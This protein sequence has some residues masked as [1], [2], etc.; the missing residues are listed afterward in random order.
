MGSSSIRRSIALRIS[1]YALT[2]V[3]AF[4]MFLAW[5]TIA[6]LS[7]IP[8]AL[9]SEE[10][11]AM[12]ATVVA[13]TG[14]PLSVTYENRWNFNDYIPLHAI[15]G[16]LRDAFIESEDRRFFRHFGVDVP[17]RLQAIIQNLRALRA[18]RGASTITEQVVRMLHPRPRT[19]W[20]RWLEGFEAVRLERRFSKHEI[21]EFYL[22]QV[23]YAHQRRGV[24]QASRYYFGRDTGE[25]NVREM[26]TL[27]VLV[28]AP[29]H[30]DLRKR[31]RRLN[32]GV[33][34]LARRMAER[35]LIPE[36]EAQA[37]SEPA[38]GWSPAEPSLPVEAGHFVR[39]LRR[40][41]TIANDSPGAKI[42][43]TLDASLQDRVE[44]LLNSR[45]RDLQS[46]G[47]SDGAA[48]VVD[49]RT[50][51]ILAWV[52]GR[53]QGTESPRAMI[54]AVLVPR[55]P[56]ST[57]KP[58]LYALALES[59]WTP[60]TL[61]EDSPLNEPVR[62]G[63]HAFHNYS[64]RYYGPLRLRECLANSLNI[65]AVRTVRR[66]SVPAFLDQLH[67][68]GFRSLGRTA[69]AYG[70]GLALGDGEVNLFEL[71]RAYTVL[72]RN[73]EF[74]PLR[75]TPDGPAQV[76]ERFIREEAASLIT[77]ILSDPDARR[78]EFGD[79]GVMRHPF[80]TAVKT[81]TSTAYRDAWTVA[82]S[83]RYTAGVWMG[84]LDGTPTRGLTGAAG[85]ALVLRGIFA[86]LH[87]YGPGGPLPSSPRLVEADICRVDGLAAG[88][89]CPRMKE[90][91]MEGTVPTV[92]CTL[93]HRARGKE[94]TNP[95][96]FREEG[97]IGT[98]EARTATE[99]ERHE[100][101]HVRLIQP[102]H[103]LRLALDPRIP[104]ELQAFAFVLPEEINPLRVEWIVDGMSVGTT[105]EN[106]RRFS[107]PL[108][109]GAHTASAR[110]RTSSGAE[111]TTGEVA[112]EVR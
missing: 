85:P 54:D 66:I 10:T 47:V 56:G 25:L 71:V 32:E 38:G 62:S 98:D 82:Y 3:I 17:A 29:S 16:T 50:D 18:V 61:I 40:F 68:L 41:E 86:E 112:F 87:R 65:P 104:P 45:L 67:R 96:S 70:E 101:R 42:V 97:K 83:D 36:A 77:D 20:S 64:R 7:P 100:P 108:V 111:E 91:F 107:W 12:R 5:K 49:H 19:L 33:R 6:G 52:N 21:L 37:T 30:F 24:L 43:S 79:G 4:G 94:R 35:G 48:L 95:E 58:F 76:G 2:G 13:R 81:G 11:G 59:G 26:L 1:L 9:L 80:P 106:T 28:R 8:P 89:D 53:A 14:T 90:R 46:M 110:I 15:P 57:L 60:A 75:F 99:E 105:G 63:L 88:P 44:K 31:N 78:L 22:N 93:N 92:A 74:R 39:A 51:E 27:A 84:N 55:Q 103:G 102:T 34:R 72:A 23:P 69:E 73:G 109:R